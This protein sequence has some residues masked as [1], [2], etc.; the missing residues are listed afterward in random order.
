MATLRS[1]TAANSVY[2]LAITGLFDTPQKLQ[3]YAADAAFASAAVRNGEIVM[4]VDGRMS[5]GFVFT[6]REQTINLQ[7]DSISCD[8]FDQW[9]AAQQ[10]AQEVFFASAI[11]TLP[12]LKKSWAGIKGIM[13]NFTPIGDVRRV[14]G[15]RV[16]QITWESLLPS[17]T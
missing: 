13:T 14:V 1:I 17:P 11:I 7:P 8:L 2:M 15:P 5:A 3:G 10:A 16:F 6:P 9:D 12:G 4:G